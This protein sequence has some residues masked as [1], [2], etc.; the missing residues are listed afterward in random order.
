M[1]SCISIGFKVEHDLM[2]N[3]N[4]VKCK[5]TRFLFDILY[6]SSCISGM[7]QYEEGNNAKNSKWSK[8][9]K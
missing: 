6:F 5:A 4:I 8:G 3:K 7:L 9:K 2:L 1:T